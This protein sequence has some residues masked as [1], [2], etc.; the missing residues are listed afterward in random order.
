MKG[1]DG[2]VVGGKEAVK[3]VWK[4]HLERL[5]NENQPILTF[6]SHTITTLSVWISRFV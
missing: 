2:V 4:R 6:H 3:S 1:E 5:M